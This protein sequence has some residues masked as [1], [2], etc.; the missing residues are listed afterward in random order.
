MKLKFSGTDPFVVKTGTLTFEKHYGDLCIQFTISSTPGETQI[1][2]LMINNGTETTK[3]G[4]FTLFEIVGVKGQPFMNTWQSWTPFRTYRKKPDIKP[5]VSMAKAS[6]NTLYSATPV[7]DI[8]ENGDLP[9]DYFI[10]FEDF[11]AGFLSSKVSHPF[12]L[13]D[14]N[15][16]H[17]KV[18]IDL[19]GKPLNPGDSIEIEPFVLLENDPLPVLLER[20][21]QIINQ[22]EQ[23][24]FKNFEGIGWCSWYQYFTETDF[25]SLKENVKLISSKKS[26][27]DLPYTLVQLDDG[28]EKDIGDWLETNDKFPELTEVSKIV[29]EKGLEPGIWLAP[30]SASETSS[31]FK[32]H[33]DWLVKDLLD[34]PKLCYRNWNKNIYALDTTHPEVEQHLKDLFK[35]LCE[36]GFTYLK[37]DFLFAGAMPGKRYDENKT[38]VEAYRKGMKIIKDNAAEDAF[39][40]GCG[41][42]LL[43]SIGFVDGMRIGADTAPIWN[44]DVPDIGIPSAKSS[45][46]NALTRYFMHR[47]LWLNDPDT[48]I[49]REEAELNDN[50]KKLVSLVSGALDNMLLHSDKMKKLGEKNLSLLKEAVT[51][52]EGKPRVFFNNNPDTYVIATK[53]GILFNCL[54]AVNL[55]D[56]NEKISIPADAMKWSGVKTEKVIDVAPHS[57]AIKKVDSRAVSLKVTREK[58]KDGREISYYEPDD[59]IVNQKS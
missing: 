45:I 40:L 48:L 8:L 56:K 49:V 43:P 18:M 38:P 57:I 26:Q 59:V 39:I 33:P 23:V 17:L 15:K 32:N 42:P 47:R 25:D 58:M 10:G 4:R 27:N 53:G 55:N 50:E 12:F 22:E 29:S 20:Y 24:R 14:E 11:V 51:L 36:I 3:P 31:I 6:G 41:A 34:K 7:P 5:L 1:D 13:L 9:S 46:R 19:F 52:S 28:Y 37:I 16:K 35:K 2:T 44:G 30:F 21:A 54:I